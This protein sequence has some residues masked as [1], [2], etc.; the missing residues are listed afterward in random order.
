MRFLLAAVLAFM[1]A[2]AVAQQL[3]YSST[4][5]AISEN[6]EFLANQFKKNSNS[7]TTGQIVFKDGTTQTTASSAVTEVG[8]STVT[9]VSPQTGI[10]ATGNPNVCIAPSTATVTCNTQCR[11][12]AHYQTSHQAGSNSVYANILFDGAFA[13]WIATGSNSAP[14]AAWDN[15]SSTAGMTCSILGPVM[16][17]GVHNVCVA[18]GLTTG[19]ANPIRAGQLSVIPTK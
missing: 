8:N 10:A 15:G 16:A 14:C 2:P 17:A 7:F 4:D 18:I 12:M 3:P 13:P 19:G 9:Y 11:L 6:F 1:A 5:T